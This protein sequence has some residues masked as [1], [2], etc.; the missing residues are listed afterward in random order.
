ME[1]KINYPKDLT[2]LVY[3]CTSETMFSVY[4]LGRSAI[5]QK[6]QQGLVYRYMIAIILKVNTVFIVIGLSNS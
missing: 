4:I 6:F 5:K 1:G 2:T 3:L